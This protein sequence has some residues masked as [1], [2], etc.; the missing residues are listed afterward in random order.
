MANA[1]DPHGEINTLTDRPRVTHL[2]LCLRHSGGL[3]AGPIIIVETGKW[4]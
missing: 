4:Y 1:V 2:S 3:Y